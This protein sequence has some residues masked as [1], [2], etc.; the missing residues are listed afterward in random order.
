[1]T[2]MDEA[3]KYATDDQNVTYMFMNALLDP[4][5][6]AYAKYLHSNRSTEKYYRDQVD[7][8]DDLANYVR[9]GKYIISLRNNVVYI[10]NRENIDMIAK[11]GYEYGKYRME[12]NDYWFNAESQLE[13]I[14]LNHEIA[15]YN[16][17]TELECASLYEY[18][19]SNYFD[20][21]GSLKSGEDFLFFICRHA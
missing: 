16:S 11:L 10:T 19:T 4:G 18:C 13:T 15:L 1:M 5:R 3:R 17:T 9:H 20:E 12:D 6:I 7:K 14:C 8:I 2:I 21:T